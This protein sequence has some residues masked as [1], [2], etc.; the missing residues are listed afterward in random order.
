[1][2]G[3]RNQPAFSIAGARAEPGADFGG[4]ERRAVPL[5]AGQADDAWAFAGKAAEK[6]HNGG[7]RA[8]YGGEGTA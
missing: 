3:F 4:A 2:V 6:T 8:R 1:M 7:G 5:Y